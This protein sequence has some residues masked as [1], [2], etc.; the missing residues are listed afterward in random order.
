LEYLQDIFLVTKLK[1]G[2]APWDA[3]KEMLASTPTDQL[4]RFAPAPAG[5]SGA[6]MDCSKRKRLGLRRIGKR[7]E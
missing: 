2:E 7:E 6:N 1:P 4:R 3:V 5:K